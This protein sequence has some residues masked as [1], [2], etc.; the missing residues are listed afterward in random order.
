M[1]WGPSS[2]AAIWPWIGGLLVTGAVVAWRLVRDII[3]GRRSR[4]AQALRGRL[5]T[6]EIGA[7]E[8]DR[9]ARTIGNPPRPDHRALYATTLVAMGVGLALI[10]LFEALGIRWAMMAHAW[11]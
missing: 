9:R 4:A 10:A 1:T 11:S 6:G 8:D 2:V 3:A 7:L 5:R